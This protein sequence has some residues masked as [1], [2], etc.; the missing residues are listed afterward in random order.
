MK[1]KLVRQHEPGD[2]AVYPRCQAPGAWRNGTR[3]AKIH[4]KP[5]D[6]HRDGARATVVASLP[7]DA[8]YFYFVRWDDR[9]EV[10]VGIASHRL[11]LLMP[12]EEER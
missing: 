6:G 12:F 7:M 2:Q 8:A 1:T 3:V 5:G 11:R 10:P 9:P 4:T